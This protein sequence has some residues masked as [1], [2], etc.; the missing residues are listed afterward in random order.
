[1]TSED[2]ELPRTWSFAAEIDRGAARPGGGREPIVPARARRQ[3]LPLRSTGTTRSSG[4]RSGLGTHPEG[5]GG[6]GSLTVAESTARSRYHAVTVAV[7]G[8]EALEGA[9]RLRPQLHPL[10]RQVRRR[11]R[12]RSLHPALRRRL[13]SGPR[14]RLVGPRPPPQGDRLPGIFTAA[15]CQNQ[16][17]RAASF[18]FA[19]LGELPGT[20]AEGPASQQ[21]GSVRDGTILE[22]NTPAP[23]QRVLHLGPV[24]VARPFALGGGRTFEPVFEIFNLTNADNSLDTAHGSLLFN[25]DGT[26]RS[27]LGDTRRCAAGRADPVFRSE[28]EARGRARLDPRAPSKC[29]RCGTAGA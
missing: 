1:M 27:G 7:R 22:R 28:A 10:L 23:R 19:R 5:G 4:R 17:Y 16:Q 20:R 21:T 26:I 2:L 25:F 14:V 24:K 18:V 6:V 15:T 9:P 3:S 8:H 29:R 13:E 11:Q 12:A